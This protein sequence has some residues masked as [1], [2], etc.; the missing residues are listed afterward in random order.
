MEFWTLSA[1]SELCSLYIYRNLITCLTYTH[2]PGEG[3]KRHLGSVRHLAMKVLVVLTLAVFAGCQANLLWQDQP[4]PSM[5]IV[6]DAFWDYVAKATLTTEDILKKIRESE[7]GQ[8]VNARI[9]ESADAVSQYAVTVRSQMT[10]MT[11]DLLAKISQEAEQLKVRLQQDLSSVQSQLEPYIQELSS[12]LQEQVEQLK[13]DVAPYTDM[14]S[15]A[16]KATLLQKSEEMRAGLEK[17]M[18]E[19]QAQL[20]PQAEELKQKMEQHMQEFQKTMI[21]M[22]ENFQDQLAHKGQEMQK[23]LDPYAEDLKAQLTTLWESFAKISQ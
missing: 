7:M 1:S 16:L 14:D 3:N 15:E 22:A 17:S 5:E 18:R 12:N 10:P 19:M 20:E 13:K 8:E 23:Q 11:Q 4:K 6:K 2:T 9:S 21:P